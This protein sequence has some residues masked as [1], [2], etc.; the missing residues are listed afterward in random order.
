[1][2]EHIKRREKDVIKNDFAKL[3]LFEAKENK[4]ICLKLNRFFTTETFHENFSSLKSDEITKFIIEQS[5]LDLLAENFIDHNYIK[6][7]LENLDIIYMR[8]ELVL[9]CCIRTLLTKDTSLKTFLNMINATSEYI[10]CFNKN[11]NK[12]SPAL[13]LITETLN[14]LQA[15]DFH[16]ISN[17]NIFTKNLM[18]KLNL[19][20]EKLPE[21][22]NLLETYHNINIDFIREEFEDPKNSD[23]IPSFNDQQMSANYSEPL[24]LNHV[25]Y[26]QQYQSAVGSFS[27]IK[28]LIKHSVKINSQQ[29]LLTCVE[30]ARLAIENPTNHEL[31]S[32]VISFME[33]FNIDTKTLRCKLRLKKLNDIIV[34]KPSGDSLRNIEALEN[35]WRIKNIANPSRT[36]LN[37]MLARSDWF[38]LILMA[39]YL[40]YP[41]Q[42]LVSIC[43]NQITNKNLRCNLIRAILYETSPEHKKRSSFSKHHRSTGSIKEFTE[44]FPRGKFLD[45]KHDLF[46]VLLKCDEELDRSNMTFEDFQRM[47]HQKFNVDD[48][49]DLL[50]YA[51]KLNWPIIAV[52][53]AMTSSVYRLKLCWITWLILSSNYDW[54]RRFKSIEDLS[55]VVIHHCIEKG[56]IKTLDESATIF[57]PH[58]AFKTFTSFLFVSIDG[59]FQEM[60]SLLKQFIVK[61]NQLKFDMVSVT[62]RK[63]ALE[64]SIRCI[65]QH[66]KMN[67]RSIVQQEKYL[68][69]LCL[70]EI[71]QFGAKVDFALVKRLCKI[72]EHSNVILDFDIFCVP[73]VLEQKSF[74]DAMSSICEDLID[75]NNFEV[76]IQI[77]ELMELPKSDLLFKWWTH[78]WDP[79]DGKSVD[80]EKYIA[81]QKKYLVGTDVLL[82]FLKSVSQTM[83]PSPKKLEVLKFILKNSWTMKPSEI[84]E[85]EYEV[86][87]LYVKLKPQADSLQTPTSEYYNVVMSKEQNIHNPLFRLKEIARID[88]LSIN[89]PL[90]DPAEIEQL[91]KLILEL[92]D[93]G[94][95]VQVLRIQEMFSQAP[96]D[97]R[98]FVYLMAISE[99][100]ASIYDISK[101]ER[102]TISSYGIMSNRFNRLTLRT[103]LKTS[104][105]TS[106]TNP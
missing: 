70:S 40:N 100:L 58:S 44:V 85:L 45:A 3:G 76:A 2:M 22:E 47:I 59:Q 82:E 105:S 7:L 92:L 56:F 1:M 95:I 93:F 55:K 24:S 25:N 83:E 101:E 72:L 104:G 34:L 97:L 5:L 50:F 103:S 90:E 68:D 28:Q 91:D 42:D 62:G 12:E 77:A 52:L 27:L 14:S 18:I 53:A 67:F 66:L 19:K 13:K 88:E 74:I 37:E 29:V 60:E 9:I 20:N 33:M 23:H 30:I 51:H 48:F 35:D 81:D 64:F 57:Y 98:I 75:D 49:N 11:F 54:N 32:H 61:L 94:D 73:N 4:L 86:I 84:D 99:G 21:I 65:V 102:Q 89:K 79:D 78:K 46:A 96:D 69:A 26:V 6:L 87:C 63:E 71:S 38:R 106:K 17:V 80:F 16:E 41:L 10:L 43:D 39:Q 8:E 31:V 36:Y 15:Q